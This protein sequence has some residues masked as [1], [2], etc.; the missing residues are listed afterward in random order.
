MMG[1]PLKASQIRSGRDV[2]KALRK[3]PVPTDT[4]QGKGSHRVTTPLEGPMRGRPITWYDHGDYPK[5][6]HSALVKLL[7]AAG[8]IIPVLLCVTSYLLST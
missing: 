3:S 4:R 8:I 7:L 1:K 2:E 6:M 5:G